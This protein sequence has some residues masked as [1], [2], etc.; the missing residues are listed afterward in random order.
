MSEK[1]V[2]QY[3]RIDDDGPSSSGKTRI[4]LVRNI[5]KGDVSG[6]IRWAGRF[7]KY[8]FFPTEG[9]HFDSDCLRLI[10]DHCDAE[11]KKHYKKI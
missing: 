10:A 1:S 9:F 8:W 2:K 5:Q 6:E 11:T 7:G 3:I 4:F